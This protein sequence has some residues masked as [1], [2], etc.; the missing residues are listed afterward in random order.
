MLLGGS[1]RFVGWLTGASGDDESLAVL[2]C[3]NGLDED[4]LVLGT[5]AFGL[6]GYRKIR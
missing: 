1:G 4:V 5:G 3:A 2:G 6:F